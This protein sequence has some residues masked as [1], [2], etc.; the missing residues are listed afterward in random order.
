VTDG[1][2]AEPDPTQ[3]YGLDQLVTT[4]GIVVWGFWNIS[5][6]CPVGQPVQTTP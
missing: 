4:T 3:L 2:L 5:V 1:Q 6:N